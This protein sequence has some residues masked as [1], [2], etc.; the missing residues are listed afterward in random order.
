MGLHANLRFAVM[1]LMLGKLTMA[2]AT[3]PG[4]YRTAPGSAATVRR[5]ASG[6]H[7]HQDTRVPVDGDSLLGQP[8]HRQTHLRPG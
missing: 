7:R 8:P 4:R 2:P 5:R 1:H 3:G 6:T